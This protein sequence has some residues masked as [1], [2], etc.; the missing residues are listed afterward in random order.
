M[1]GST[2]LLPPLLLLS[3]ASARPVEFDGLELRAGAGLLELVQAEEQE[4]A[5][6]WRRQDQANATT[7]SAT[8]AG[9]PTSCQSSAA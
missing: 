6:V 9:T 3:S 2:L 4:V 1:L 5:R 8:P 7:T